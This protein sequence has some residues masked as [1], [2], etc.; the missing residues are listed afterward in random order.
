MCRQLSAAQRM[1][2]FGGLCV[3][4]RLGDGCLDAANGQELMRSLD[5][6]LVQLRGQQPSGDD[7]YHTI[8][9]KLLAFQSTAVSRNAHSS[10]DGGLGYGEADKAATGPSL[11]A[12]VEGGAPS[13]PGG[14]GLVDE[15]RKVCG[16]MSLR[17]E[18]KAMKLLKLSSLGSRCC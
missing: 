11:G 8:R 10:S 9:R 1:Q 7:D 17:H 2:F 5:Y 15:A 18:L 12:V 3:W 16:C 6:V 13:L 14:T 4:L